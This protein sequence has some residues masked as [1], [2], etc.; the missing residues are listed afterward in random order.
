[1]NNNVPT[2][3]FEDAIKVAQK[4][5]NLLY[6]TQREMRLEEAIITEDN[7]TYEITFSFTLPMTDEPTDKKKNESPSI[8]DLFKGMDKHRRFRKV[9]LIDSIDGK[10]KGLKEKD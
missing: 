8:I 5:F 1:M 2:I 6:P 10:F 9:F 7:K 4:N 3:S